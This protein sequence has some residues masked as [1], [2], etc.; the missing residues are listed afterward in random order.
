[1]GAGHSFL[2]LEEPLS[3]D[4][5]SLDPAPDKSGGLPPDFFSLF[6][7]K[8]SSH[9][10]SYFYLPLFFRLTPPISFSFLSSLFFFFFFTYRNPHHHC[11]RGYSQDEPR[12]VP[13]S[14]ASLS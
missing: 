13:A 2:V 10:T 6:F 14:Q 5:H 1:M 11:H 7:L 3:E 12:F 8:P 9:N 4:T